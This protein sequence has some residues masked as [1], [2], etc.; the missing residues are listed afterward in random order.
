[1]I[2]HYQR[3]GRLEVVR[4]PIDINALAQEIVTH[5]SIAAGSTI[6]FATGFA[7]PLAP[8]SADRDLLHAALE[9][10][11]R[12]A[13]EALPDGGK[14]T[15]TTED[16]S[17]AGAGFV[18]IAVEDT[19]LGMSPRITEHAFDDFFTTKSTGTG[20]GLPFVRRVAEAH[21]G[22]V[23]LHSVEGEGTVVR[24]RMRVE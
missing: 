5:Q 22:D 6:E 14:I 17:T 16:G 19:G 11:V 1:M 24:W 2:S 23:T 9:N 13:I 18:A 15:V 21:G 10:V 4:E 7:E 8:C 3:L 20:L 12:N